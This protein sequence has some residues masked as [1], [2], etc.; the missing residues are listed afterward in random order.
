ML[1]LK[2]ILFLV[3][4]F[5]INAQ[6]EK[7]SAEKLKQDLTIFK[8][9]RKKANSGVYKYRTPK[10]IDSIY[11]WAFLQI[12]KPKTLL[13]FYKIVLKITDFE[14]SLHNDTTL[15]DDFQKKYSSGNLFFPYPVKLIK[16]KLVVNFRN[17][18][19]PL[20]SHIHSIN[21]I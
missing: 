21:K 9:I 8:E 15:P 6:N 11:S 1:K 3:F 18:K 13:D 20:G 16:N 19:I 12:N 10:Q 5:F 2:I 14:G 4:P 7:I 17:T